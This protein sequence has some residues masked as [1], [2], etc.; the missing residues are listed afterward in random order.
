MYSKT[1]IEKSLVEDGS[2]DRSLENAKTIMHGGGYECDGLRIIYNKSDSSWLIIMH[3]KHNIHG[4]AI[5]HCF[6]GFNLDIVSGASALKTAFKMF[7]I[8]PHYDPH[9]PRRRY[10]WGCYSRS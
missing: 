8:N 4:D 10:D 1:E 3:F 5:E 2:I 9:S 7:N 6:N